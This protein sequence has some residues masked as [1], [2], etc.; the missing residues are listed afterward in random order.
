MK[1][2][3]LINS[4]IDCIKGYNQN[5]EGPDSWAERF[6][7]KRIKDS[8]ERMFIK[9]VFYGVLQYKDFLKV[10]TDNLFSMNKSTTERKDENLY[11]II[12]YLTVFRLDEL[13][14]EDYKQII[15]VRN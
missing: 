10:F 14:L 2:K 3:E 11:H 5:V 15:V 12:G 8:H 1:F 6:M 9:Q 13:P 7:S 4:T